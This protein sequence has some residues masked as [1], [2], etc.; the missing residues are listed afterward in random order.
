MYK[1][2]LNTYQKV[3]ITT[4]LATVFLIFIGSLV[5]ASGAGLGCPD[6]PKCFGMWIPPTSAAD[7]PA[8]FDASEFNV[9]KTW[10]EYVNRLIGVLIGILITATFVLS[11]RYKKSKPAVFYS[12]G[13]AFLMVLY[14]G[15]LGGQVVKTGLH[16][17]LITLHMVLAMAIMG[18]LLYAV[19]KATSHMID[20]HL[21]DKV[22][23]K[24]YWSILVLLIFTVAQ[25]V[26][27]TQVRE[28][29]D[30]I[31]NSMTP[32][33]RTQWLDI[34]GNIDEIHRTFSWSVFLSG[35][36]TYYLS[37]RKTS[38]VLVQWLGRVIMAFI[39]LQIAV[40]VGLY[41]FGIPPVLQILHL[42]A[43]AIMF[44]LEFL[45]LLVVRLSEK[46]ISANSKLETA[47]LDD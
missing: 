31:K 14:Q 7:L 41:Y 40:G 39:L 19:F 5:R 23:Q 20:S 42:T 18:V 29:V 17:G 35:L 36:Y 4:V 27:G 45:L 24:L 2:K 15:W 33:P 22:R 8:Q 37:M 47:V 46:R 30:V 43:M 9:V 38:S 6:W 44:C 3:A 21:E 13:A 32:P 28:A 12:S 25:V 34:I 1:M 26:L 11:F 16:E 10:T